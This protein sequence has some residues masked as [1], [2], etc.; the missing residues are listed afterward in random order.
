MFI[1]IC[2]VIQNSNKILPHHLCITVIYLWV[3]KVFET[4]VGTNI[5][6]FM[7]HNSSI[8][9][10]FSFP[11]GVCIFFHMYILTGFWC[12]FPTGITL[13]ACKGKGE[14]FVFAKKYCRTFMSISDW[15]EL[16]AYVLKSVLLLKVFGIRCCLTVI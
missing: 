15:I 11:K 6:R 10:E 14:S 12:L 4:L 5:K 13:N 2:K 8:Y 9:K 16:M 1:Q 7:V 3:R